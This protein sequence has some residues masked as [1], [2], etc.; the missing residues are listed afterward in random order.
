MLYMYDEGEDED[1][2]DVMLNLSGK[3][4]MSN[5]TST[6]P[7]DSLNNSE[8]RSSP[9]LPDIPDH[10]SSDTDSSA[11][12]LSNTNKK[13]MGNKD[14]LPAA[15]YIPQNY[16]FTPYNN[17]NSGDAANGNSS[18]SSSPNGG[19]GSS[20]SNSHHPHP[21]LQ[22]VG[23]SKDRIPAL[24]QQ[25]FEN[26]NNTTNNN[27]N[28]SNNNLPSSPT[29]SITSTAATAAKDSSDE[30]VREVTP[31]NI[32]LRTNPPGTSPL[33]TPPITTT[34][35]TTTTTSNNSSLLPNANNI[36]T[37]TNTIGD[38]LIALTSPLYSSDS[39]SGAIQPTQSIIGTNSGD[40]LISSPSN[41]LA[42][43]SNEDNQIRPSKSSNYV[44]ITDFLS[45]PQ[46]DAAKK[47][48][49]PTSTL[50]KRWKEAAPGRKWPYR[51]ITKLEKEIL[52]VL[53]NIPEG[54]EMSLAVKENLDRLT[55]KRQSELRP[56]YIRL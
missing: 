3:F 27:S 47:L 26:T 40:H 8:V 19:G 5:S 6:T 42:L 56:V 43:P 54:G 35:T 2:D 31:S 4:F 32:I 28:N 10:S 48:G 55:K 22:R 7:Q 53:H 34:T 46:G 37:T 29:N 12:A 25:Y 17:N 41:A 33:S 13:N 39:N 52:T 36:L 50:S 18:S 14:E 21:Y 9:L 51:Q 30:Q 44:D 23:L 15:L 24:L 11:P 20:S 16:Q 45:L 1:E 49:I 38:S